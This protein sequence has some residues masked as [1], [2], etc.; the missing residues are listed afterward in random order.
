[1]VDREPAPRGPSDELGVVLE[2]A[3]E[4]GFL[5][6]GPTERQREHS[7]ELARLVAPFAG[8]FLDLG[9]GGGLPGFV[10]A[11]ELAAATGSLLDAQQR[12]CAFL[13]HAIGR[14]RLG[15]RLTV[16][17]G[18]AE[19]LARNASHRRAF[20]LVVA[21]SFGPPAVTAE[22]AVGFLRLG[23]RLVVTEPPDA[24]A[25]SA[26]WPPEAISLLGLSD[27][28]PLRSGETAAVR[29]TLITLEE[30]YPRR[31]GIPGKRPL[32]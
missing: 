20:D 11:Q 5:G 30:R 3:R 7:V 12:R 28:H 8:R 1:M 22:C 10:L 13:E 32:W 16:A 21:R 6:P 31:E 25:S 9:S 2:D 23:G 26:R 19:T 29:M 14:L 17:C 15:D 24:D 18:R 27:V 4:L